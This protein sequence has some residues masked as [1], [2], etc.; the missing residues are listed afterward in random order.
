MGCDLFSLHRK[1]W[2]SR[3]SNLNETSNK[4]NIVKSKQKSQLI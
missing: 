2:L 4:S 3:R 1:V